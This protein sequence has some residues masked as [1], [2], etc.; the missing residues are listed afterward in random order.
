[1]NTAKQIMMIIKLLQKKKRIISIRPVLWLTGCKTPTHSLTWG[2]YSWKFQC[3]SRPVSRYMGAAIFYFIF[4]F[5]GG[6]GGGGA[7]GVG[8]WG[9]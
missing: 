5:F 4:F 2:L 1:M 3:F 7:V 8:G 9:A 6:G